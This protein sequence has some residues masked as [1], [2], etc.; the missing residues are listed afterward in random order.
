MLTNVVRMAKRVKILNFGILV[1]DFANY[2]FL[3]LKDPRRVLNGYVDLSL[4][5]SFL[6]PHTLLRAQTNSL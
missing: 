1:T 6:N 3:F 2:N 5:T 4:A